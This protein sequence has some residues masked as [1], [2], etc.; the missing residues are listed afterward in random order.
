MNWDV[1]V[2]GGGPAGSTLAASLAARGYRVGVLERKTF[3][4]RKLC[5]EFLAPEGVALLHRLGVL[6]SVLARGAQ[7]VRQA[8]FVSTRGRT[9]RIPLDRF[10]EGVGFGLGISRA[11]LDHRLLEHARDQGADVLEGVCVIAP[12]M[13]GERIVGV[14]GR[15]RASEKPISFH[16]SLVIDASGRSRVLWP[17]ANRRRVSSRLFAF[18]VHLR[19]V[20][21]IQE[22]VELYFYPSGYGGLVRI[23]DGLCNLCAITTQDVMRCAGHRLERLLEATIAQNPL[24]REKLRRARPEGTVLGC[25][26]LEFAL[27]ARTRDHL[28]IGDAAAQ[29]DPF[30]G[31]GMSLALASGLVAAACVD[32]AFGRGDPRRLIPDVARASRRLFLRRWGV[33]RLLRP[34]VLQQEMRELVLSCLPQEGRAQRV[35]LRL[36]LGSLARS[37]TGSV[38]S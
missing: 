3:P 8:V 27:H 10:P 26:P 9:W 2:I 15:A 28:A 20:E 22:S 11:A 23:E 7:P 21:G 6:E 16:A 14:N 34:L 4:R 38:I 13:R 35:L 25:G 30:L 1:L 19:G 36:L 37:L 29:S 32:E 33:G 17:V 24:A 31:Q 12:I 18:S 5:G